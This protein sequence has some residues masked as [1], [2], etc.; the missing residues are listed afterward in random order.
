MN[1]KLF[2]VYIVESPSDP[3]LYLKRFEGEALQKTLELSE[4]SSSHKLVV[5]KNALEAAFGVGL[6]EHFKSSQIS[7][8]IHI[9]AH[10]FKGGIQL[11]NKEIV[12]W[13]DLRKFLIP[14]NKVLGGGLLLSMSTCNG[15]SG[16]IMAMK[17][18]EFPFFGVVG[19]QQTP[20]WSETNIAYATFYH[21]F[22]KGYEIDDA[23]R[24]MNTASGNNYFVFI[25]SRVARQAY[26]EEIKSKEAITTM[27]S[28]INKEK[29]N[30]FE[31]ALVK[32][33]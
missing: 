30:P 22:S 12:S 6:V 33:L 32:N 8:I 20:T 11:T 21:L 18:E 29:P 5:S 15:S 16:C 3:D 27:N 14:V 9:S 19:N 4:I 10:G 25:P 23:V 2:H 26:L 13:N 28:I 17:D 24:A 7:P 31:K 1:P